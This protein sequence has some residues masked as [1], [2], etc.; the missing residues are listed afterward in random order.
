MATVTQRPSF[1][2]LLV[3]DWSDFV[4]C[5]FGRFDYSFVHPRTCLLVSPLSAVPP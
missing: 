2:P 4:G 5:W 1:P 3:V